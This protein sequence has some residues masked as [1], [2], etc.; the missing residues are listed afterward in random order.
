[1]ALAAK[2]WGSSHTPL[3]TVEERPIT[4]AEEVSVAMKVGRTVAWLAKLEP[5]PK[6]VK[7]PKRERK[8]RR[9]TDFIPA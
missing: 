6:N 3:A 9:S 7:S 4:G 1:M 5:A 2:S 8:L